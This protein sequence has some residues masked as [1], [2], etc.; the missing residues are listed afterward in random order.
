MAF[1]IAKQAVGLWGPKGDIY[2]VPF[3]PEAQLVPDEYC[4]G[5]AYQDAVKSGFLIEVAPAS[6]AE[7]KPEPKKK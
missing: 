3:R 4:Q 7:D 5:A 2:D 1:V 6:A